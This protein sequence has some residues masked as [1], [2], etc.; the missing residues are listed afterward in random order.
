MKKA[1]ASE[2]RERPPELSPRP[3]PSP[4][5]LPRR[6]SVVCPVFNEAFA[7]EA[8]YQEIRRVL[9][10]KLSSYDWEIIFADNGSTD[11]TRTL[12]R[13][14]AARENRVRVILNSRNFGPAASHFNA[15]LASSGDVIVVFIPADLQD[16]PSLIPELVQH[17]EEGYDVVYGIRTDRQEGLLLRGMRSL[18]YR[19]VAAGSPFEVPLDAGDF[20][21]IDRQ[22]LEALRRF[23]DYYPYTRGMIAYCGFR[24]IGVP[25]K[26][27]ERNLGETKRTSYLYLDQAL[28]GILSFTNIP[29]RLSI[30]VG[31]LTSVT[32]IIYGSW[33]FLA[34]LTYGRTIQPGLRTVIV[35]LFLLSGI[36][37]L[38]L[39][40][41]GEYIYAI[42]S[43]VRSRPLVI[44]EE[45]LNFQD[46]APCPRCGLAAPDGR[47]LEGHGG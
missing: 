14:L 42:Y 23:R 10:E 15:L 47:W 33:S 8:C 37:L 9:E 21:V 5:D 4:S 32:S 30:L 25:Y 2:E 24:S 35:A 16:P 28:N 31:L 44:E 39:G 20:Q 17:W 40:V 41:I 46:C 36:I 45:R 43:Q 26:W 34:A 18:F 6:I 38:V 22:V 27:G 11:G 7:L 19:L 3:S 12:L 29:L 1:E 13:D